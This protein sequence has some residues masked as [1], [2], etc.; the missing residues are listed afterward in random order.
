MR[1]MRRCRKSPFPGRNIFIPPR[2]RQRR[3]IGL[4]R[5]IIG[6][7][8][9][10]AGSCAQQL[11][12]VVDS[13]GSNRTD[14]N[15]V[16]ADALDGKSE[17]CDADD[18]CYGAYCHIHRLGKINFILYPYPHAKHADHAVQQRSHPAQDTLGYGVDNGAEL[19]AEA[20]DK[21]KQ[22]RKPLGGSRIDF[23]CSHNTNIFSIRRGA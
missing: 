8:L 2:P 3:R 13:E 19:G 14:R 11:Q 20:E 9:D 23:C 10:D 18:H 1:L 5:N 7:V 22:C 16:E 15:T 17:I 21:C 6:A 4:L 12:K